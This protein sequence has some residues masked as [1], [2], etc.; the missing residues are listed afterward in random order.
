[1][2]IKQVWPAVLALAI[3][4]LGVVSVGCGGGGG[5][6]GGGDGNPPTYVLTLRDYRSA[7]NAVVPG[8]RIYLVA[9]TGAAAQMS[10]VTFTDGLNGGYS[11]DG[12]ATVNGLPATGILVIPPSSFYQAYAGVFNAV[13]GRVEVYQQ[14]VNMNGVPMVPWNPADAAVIPL[15]IASGNLGTIYVYTEDANSFPPVPD[16]PQ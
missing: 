15:T 1:M 3:A 7:S 6:G 4:L 10:A 9:G 13:R 8:A 2:T 5:D 14:P 11:W 16:Y 12:P